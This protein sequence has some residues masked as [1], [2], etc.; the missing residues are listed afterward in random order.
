MVAVNGATGA[1]AK[2]DGSPPEGGASMGLEPQNMRQMWWLMERLS[3]TGFLPDAIKTPGQALAIVLAGRELGLGAMASLRGIN[4]IKGKV[5]ISAATQLGLMLKAGI[6][7]KW[8]EQ[9]AARACIELKREGMEAA[10]FSFTMDEAKQAGLV[11]GGGNYSKFP[12]AMLRARAITTGARAYAADILNDCYDPAELASGPGSRG[13][14]APPEVREVPH[15][16]KT[17]E[18]I[19]AQPSPEPKRTR[20][21]ALK[22]KLAPPPPEDI[23]DLSIAFSLIASQTD[24]AGINE[25]MARGLPKHLRENEEVKQAA[26]E[27]L[28]GLAK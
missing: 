18:V 9:S 3:G 23:E 27:K 13:D 10:Q 21:D 2:T 20:T 4:I 25:V 6:K 1:L 15:D 16:P 22:E 14:D 5:S 17:G 26:A 19:E 28:K 12:P 8:I 7:I 11:G 24:A